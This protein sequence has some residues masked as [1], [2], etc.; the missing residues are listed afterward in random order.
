METLRIGQKVPEFELDTY[1]P[2]EGRYGRFNLRDAIAK[3]QWTILVFYPAD[4]TFVCP[5]ELSDLAERQKEFRDMGCD[6]VSVSTDTKFV[7]LAWQLQ[8]KLLDKVKYHMGADPN[9]SLSRMFG[10]YDENSGLAFRGTFIIS[11]DGTIVS[12]EVNLNNVGRNADELVRK[13][14]AFIYVREHPEEV[15]PAK[16]KP[17]ART[18]KPD[19]S[20][21]GNVYKKVQNK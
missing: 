2:Q 20:L 18:L 16:W 9:G 4:F 14:S 15:C 12:T 10:V 5:T 19:E 17:G 6:I 8:E 3:K 21:V 11:P 13:V 1:E 7:H